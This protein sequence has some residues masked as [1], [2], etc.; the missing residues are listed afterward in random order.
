M[1]STDAWMSV[2]SYTMAM[3]SIGQGNINAVR[4]NEVG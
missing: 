4:E 2:F 1:G 3:K